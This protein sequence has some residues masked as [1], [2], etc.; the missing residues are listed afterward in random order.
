MQVLVDRQT[1][2]AVEALRVRKLQVVEA[3]QDVVL[4]VTEEAV[5]VV[6]RP[7]MVQQ[8]VH[9]PA[10]VAAVPVPVRLPVADVQRRVYTQSWL[11]PR[12]R[13]P[14]R[15]RDVSFFISNVLLRSLWLA[16][17]AD[18]CRWPTNQATSN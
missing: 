5:E 15:R 12:R 3:V 6:N 2:S 18:A 17:D 11:V 4:G 14:A 8:P 1:L 16:D 7:V 10:A 13:S 9:M